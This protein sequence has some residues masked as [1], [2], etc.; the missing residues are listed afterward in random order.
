MTARTEAVLKEALELPSDERELPVAELLAS[1]DADA[2]EDAEVAW[3]SEIAERAR[4]VLAGTS[5]AK[6]WNEFR[7]RIKRE[8]SGP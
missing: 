7:D 3:A 2:Y 4:R 8:V 6:P 1:L 5:S